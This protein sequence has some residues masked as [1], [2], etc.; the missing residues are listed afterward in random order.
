[1]KEKEIKIHPTQKPIA[2]YK[3]ILDK[4]AKAGDKI[5]DTHAGSGSS[6]LACI[7]RG[8]TYTAFEID[9]KYYQL[10]SSRIEQETRQISIFELLQGG[11]NE[12]DTKTT[13]S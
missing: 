8:F 11:Q 2:L 13:Q 6:I 4:F 1:M 10:T 12:N 3:W 7:D 5:L 9:E